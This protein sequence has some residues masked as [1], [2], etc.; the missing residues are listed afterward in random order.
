M[1][2]VFA[3]MSSQPPFAR[4]CSLLRWSG[5][6]VQ[7]ATWR[8]VVTWLIAHD[9]ADLGLTMDLSKLVVTMEWLI[10]G[11]YVIPIYSMWCAI[12]DRH[13]MFGLRQPL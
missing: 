9:A 8:R 1:S 11:A 10:A 7:A 3:S 2:V 12:E 6:R 5:A 4:R 13:C